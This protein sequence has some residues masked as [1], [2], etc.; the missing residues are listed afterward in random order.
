MYTQLYLW[1]TNPCLALVPACTPFEPQVISVETSPPQSSSATRG[2][3]RGLQKG[4]RLCWLQVLQCGDCV[5][6]LFWA[7]EAVL[8]GAGWAEKSWRSKV[9]VEAGLVGVEAALGV[10]GAQLFCV[11]VPEGLNHLLW[12]GGPGTKLTPDSWKC[13]QS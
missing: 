4:Q 12:V 6:V 7:R 13:L 8:C 2:L 5:R 3:K 1:G 11:E 10:P 9:G